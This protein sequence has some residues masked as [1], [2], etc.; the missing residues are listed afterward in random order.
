[1]LQQYPDDWSCFDVIAE[2]MR[3][4]G[5]MVEA[6]SGRDASDPLVRQGLEWGEILLTTVRGPREAPK[7]IAGATGDNIIPLPTKG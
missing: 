1:M 7:L 6:F 4:Y 5:D 3:A 2:A